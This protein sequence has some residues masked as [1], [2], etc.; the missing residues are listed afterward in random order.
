MTG[1]L[2]PHSE[3]VTDRERSVLDAHLRSRYAR[4]FSDEAIEGHIRD[5]V[6]FTFADNVVGMVL[7]WAGAGATLL[8]IGCGF[9]AFVLR[10]RELGMDARGVEMAEFEVEFARDRLRRLRPQDDPADIYRQGDAR[11][12]ELATGSLD[13]VTLWNVIEHIDDDRAVLRAVHRMLRPGGSLYLI[14]PNYAAV[15]QEAHY[16]VPWYP[17][18]PK[19]LASRYLAAKGKDP[20]YLRSEI[21]YRTNWGLLRR[22]S[23]LGFDLYTLDNTTPMGP[24]KAFLRRPRAFLEFYN[25]FKDSVLLAARKRG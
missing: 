24:S 6:G 12:L 25:P 20:G 16:H 15:R 10:A 18:F 1:V 23:G 11:F 9:G 3:A 4:V 2:I 19:A 7:A 17:F 21:F 5:Y 22:L 8:D 13:V 14:C